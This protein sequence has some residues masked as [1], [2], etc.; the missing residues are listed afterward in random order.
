M[1]TKIENGKL[2]V[3]GITLELTP[4]QIKQLSGQEEWPKIG[5]EFF[6]LSGDI[7]RSIRLPK[8]G[9]FEMTLRDTGNL[10]RTEEAAEKHL[11]YLKALQRVKEY[12]R[13]NDLGKEWGADGDNY[14]IGWITPETHE[15]LIK[16]EFEWSYENTKQPHPYGYL[17]SIEACTQLIKDCEADLKIIFDVN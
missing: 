4:E 5:D 3:D 17:K 15:N 6:Y 13:K 2:V 11:N 8:G 1:Q 12:I 9:D 10:F 7:C 14:F 16:G